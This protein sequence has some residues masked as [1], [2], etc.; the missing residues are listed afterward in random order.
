MASALFDYSSNFDRDF[1][2]STC[3]E[4]MPEKVLTNDSLT[5][6]FL[7]NLQRTFFFRIIIILS[8]YIQLSIAVAQEGTAGAE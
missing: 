7:H 2:V 5:F 1:S 4:I 8:K 6:D 3:A